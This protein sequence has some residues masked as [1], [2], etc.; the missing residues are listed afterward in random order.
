MARDTD[1]GVRARTRCA[2]REIIAQAEGALRELEALDA[3]ASDALERVR[4]SRP[5]REP[6]VPA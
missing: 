2:L 6:G 3:E 1:R 4:D 5:P